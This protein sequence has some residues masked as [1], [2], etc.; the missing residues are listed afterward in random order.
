MKRSPLLQARLPPRNSFPF[1]PLCHNQRNGI[2]ALLILLSALFVT[3]PACGAESTAGVA[4]LVFENDH[5]NHTDRHYTNGLSLGWAPA[6]SPTPPWIMTIARHTPFFPTNSIIRH[7]YSL[8]QSTFTP[9]DIRLDNP[10]PDDRPYAGWLHGS[11]SMETAMERQFDQLVLTLGVVGPASLA[12][13]GQK[14]L[15]KVRAVSKPRGWDKQLQNEP[16]LI[17]TYQRSWRT[18]ATNTVTGLDFDLAPHVGG[19]LGNIF[20]YADTGLTLRLGRNLPRD[21]GPPRIQPGLPGSM[22][23]TTAATSNWYLFAGIE[24]RALARNVFLDGN[25]FRNSR[26][27]DKKTFVGD[28]QVGGVL[29]WRNVRLSYTHVLR[30]DEFKNQRSRDAFGALSLA[31]QY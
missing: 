29:T 21:L 31:L 14:A 7:S 28:L 24:G 13:T 27:V 16:G 4:S 11:L 26:S 9:G 25:T 6:T 8:S 5:F 19:A 18:L 12:E 20:T 2:F 17:V 15:H 10:P 1:W 3:S 22:I 30:S 23:F